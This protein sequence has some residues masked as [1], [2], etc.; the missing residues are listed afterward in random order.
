MAI[1][2]RESIAARILNGE[3]LF[4]LN[5]HL[6]CVPHKWLSAHPGGALSILHFTGR[7]ATDEVEAY[8]P[9]HALDKMR[10]FS[11]GPVQL[12]EEGWVPLLPPIASGWISKL[13]SD[14]SLHWHNEATPDHPLAS[15]PS[16]QILLVKKS[17]T[18]LASSLS[19]DSLQP[20]PT[21]LS[22]KIQSQHSAAYKQLHKRI[23]DAGLY[24]TRYISGYGPEVARYIFFA[25]SSYFLYQRHWFFLS[26]FSL[27]LLWHQLVFLCHDLGH[28][29]VTHSWLKDRLIA[30][31]IADFIGGLSIGWWVHNHN[32]HHVVTNHPSHDPDIQHLPFFAITPAFFKSLYSSYY[33]RELT[34]DRFSRAV[35]TAQHRLFYVIMSLARFNLYR[36]SYLHLWITRNEPS[37]ARGGRWAWWFEV[38]ALFGFLFWYGS[39]LRGCGSWQ[40]GLMYLLV[41]NMVPSPLHVQI[42]LSHYS[43]STAD[44]G[45]TE[46][47]P[48]R[49]L[50]TTTDVICHPFVEFL[51]GGLH[52]QV[53]HHLFPRLPRHNL[54]EASYFVKEFAKE[55][56]LEYA[57]FGFIEGNGEVQDTLRGVANQLRIMKM[58]ADSEIRE[59]MDAKTD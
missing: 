34:F 3:H 53:T 14:G 46:S 25:L 12:S 26:A 4:I 18:P 51:H 56:G 10:A 57:E 31:C 37:K 22:L 54:K 38:F 20:P 11:Q 59:A 50:R 5:G 49:Q 40:A 17:D 28:V 7:D 29:S 42:V 35:V 47:F 27:G 15:S 23:L 19:L 8:H 9:K 1:H 52:L 39:A 24:Q 32:V 13:S 41:S 43:R 58:V 45:P 55:Q 30:I 2:S 33:K 44:L 6:I 16:S 36:L 48:H 21:P